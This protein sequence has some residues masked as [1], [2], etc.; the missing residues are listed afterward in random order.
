[1]VIRCL[2]R[3]CPCVTCGPVFF[4]FVTFRIIMEIW[5]FCLDIWNIK[6]CLWEPCA[7]ESAGSAILTQVKFTSRLWDV[8]EQVYR[9]GWQTKAC[10]LI[11]LYRFRWKLL[12]NISTIFHCCQNWSIFVELSALYTKYS[13]KYFTSRHINNLKKCKLNNGSFKC[14]SVR[15]KRSVTTSPCYT[16]SRWH[17]RGA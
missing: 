16:P 11:H 6:A 8:W 1:M 10:A 3:P 15:S 9:N 14:H 5:D 17:E 13:S 4:R 12:R 2:R 7:C